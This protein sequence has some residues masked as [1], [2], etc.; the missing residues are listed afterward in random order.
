MAPSQPDRREYYRI[1]ESILM[2]YSIITSDE[3][4]SSSDSTNSTLEIINEFSNVSAQMKASLGRISERSADIASCLK[5]LDTKINLLAQV[6]LVN[7]ENQ[8][9]KRHNIN[10][11]AGGLAFANQ[12]AINDNAYL[13]LKL[14]LPPDLSMLVIKG[15]VVS[16]KRQDDFDFPYQISVEF[17]NLNDSEQDSIARH[18]MRLQ[19][20]QLRQRKEKLL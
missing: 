18:I 1:E 2:T 9:L 5:S 10:I 15:R 8:A 12:E 4:L 7:G 14:I 3:D 16:C 20:Q 17:I 19:A 13:Q 6:L 11:S